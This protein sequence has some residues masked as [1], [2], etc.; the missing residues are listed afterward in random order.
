MSAFSCVDGNNE[1]ALQL[2]QRLFSIHLNGPEHLARQRVL[3]LV[4]HFF[5]CSQ[6]KQFDKISREM[7]ELIESPSTKGV[8]HDQFHCNQNQTLLHVAIRAKRLKVVKYLLQRRACIHLKMDPPYGGESRQDA[9][10]VAQCSHQACDGGVEEQIHRLVLEIKSHPDVFISYRQATEK[11]IAFQLYQTLT[12]APH[13]ANVFLDSSPD[14]GIPLGEEWQPY[15]TKILVQSRV[16]IPIVSYDGVLKKI[17]NSTQDTQSQYADNVLLEYTVAAALPAIKIIPLWIGPGCLSPP[18][19][20]CESSPSYP[21]NDIVQLSHPLPLEI[22]AMSS[23]VKNQPTIEAA[24]RICREIFA[25]DLLP[26]ILSKLN[27]ELGTLWACIK[28]RNGFKFEDADLSQAASVASQQQTAAFPVQAL[29]ERNVRIKCQKFCDDLIRRTLA[30]ITWQPPPPPQTT[31]AGVLSILRGSFVTETLAQSIFAL[32][33]FCSGLGFKSLITNIRAGSIIIRFQLLM[34]QNS[35]FTTRAGYDMLQRQH[36][37]GTL[38]RELGLGPLKFELENCADDPLPLLLHKQRYHFEELIVQCI[39][40]VQLKPEYSA[41]DIAV[42]VKIK[43][44]YSAHDVV[45]MSSGIQNRSDPEEETYLEKDWEMSERPSSKLFSWSPTP[46]TSSFV[47]AASRVDD[48][49]KLSLSPDYDDFQTRY[50]QD[51]P[52]FEPPPHAAGH[53]LCLASLAYYTSPAYLVNMD[54][55][56]QAHIIDFEAGNTCF[57][58]TH[59][60][61]VQQLIVTA[62]FPNIL[63]RGHGIEGLTKEIIYSRMKA[64]DYNDVFDFGD[65]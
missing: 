19:H 58:P 62:R 44:E 64:S 25:D 49:I 3:L 9:L 22:A 13:F 1:T 46:H 18:P 59:I 56:Q 60:M 24:R 33:N 17:V 50:W 5:L 48:A 26:P 21:W 57:G 27:V 30:S 2:A 31:R 29:D 35:T 36:E 10:E 42:A 63:L 39:G 41:Q 7:R 52:S 54:P 45:T 47:A 28:A 15:F 16:F 4:I 51:R 65:K 12:Q 11:D 34:T 61:R 23:V 14:T 37:N 53:K 32:S 40:N 43:P 38:E 55:A 8:I 20:G 6:I